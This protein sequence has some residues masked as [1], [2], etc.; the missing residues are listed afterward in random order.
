M[1]PATKTP[2]RLSEEDR[3]QLQRI[4]VEAFPDQEQLRRMV[5]TYLDADM[6]MAISDA[7]IADEVYALIWMVANRQRDEDLVMAALAANPAYTPL[8][9]F[10]L[11]WANTSGRANQVL[12]GALR[13][14]PSDPLL[15][16]TERLLNHLRADLTARTA[17]YAQLGRQLTAEREA[18]RNQLADAQATFRA[19]LEA[20]QAT[21]RTLLEVEQNA[22]QAIF[23]ENQRLL[24]ALDQT[25]RS[26]RDD[27]AKLRGSYDMQLADLAAR[28]DTLGRALAEE[29][30]E[31][32]FESQVLKADMTKLKLALF[33]ISTALAAL[34]VSV[35]LV[36]IGAALVSG[37]ALPWMNLSWAGWGPL[38]LFLIFFWALLYYALQRTRTRFVP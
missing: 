24:T 7:P 35:C 3:E 32:H 11:N 8:R 26:Q 30:K 2:G 10:A 4:L 36:T 15:L 6:A 23:E 18:H 16:E 20:E 21:Q 17:S 25:R 27:L 5:S 28:R 14:R 12:V 33:T 22:H 19:Q 34:I 13:K 1:E 38:I 37:V 31:R 29:R 9:D